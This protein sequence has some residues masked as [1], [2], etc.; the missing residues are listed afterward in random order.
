M[1]KK[2]K[3][4]ADRIVSISAILM[5]LMTLVVLIV[6]TNMIR[7]QQ[8]NSVYP[9]LMMGNQGYG[10]A[11]FAYIMT[12]SGIG[13]AIIESVE[14]NYQDSIYQMDL[15]SFFFNHIEGSDTLSDVLHSNIYPGMLIPA[16]KTINFFEVDNN[17]ESAISLMKALEKLQ[18]EEFEMVITYKS[19]YED[20]WQLSTETGTP[21]PLN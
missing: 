19:I 4:S 10:G 13:P 11:N 9:H 17:L 3:I 15:P 5:S 8:R 20:K 21:E 12:N 6:Q 1:A 16:E 18:E 7:H 2:K 14:I